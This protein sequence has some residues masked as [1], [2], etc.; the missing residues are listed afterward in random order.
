MARWHTHRVDGVE[1]P[2][3]RRKRD[4]RNAHSLECNMSNCRGIGDL[5]QYE[6]LI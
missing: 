5:L 4:K 1:I 6:K 2:E 3:A